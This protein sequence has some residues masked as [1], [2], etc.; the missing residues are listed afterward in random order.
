MIRGSGDR[1]TGRPGR[2]R[3]RRSAPGPAVGGSG[4]GSA[5]ASATV[6]GHG[7]AEACRRG[8]ASTWVPRCG[9]TR[10][11]GVGGRRPRPPAGRRG[12][13]CIEV[14]AGVGW[15]PPAG[16]CRRTARPTRE[17]RPA[18][19]S[20]GGRR[21]RAVV[22]GRVGGGSTSTAGQEYPF[23]SLTALHHGTSRQGSSIKLVFHVKQFAGA[24][25]DPEP[26]WDRDPRRQGTPARLACMGVGRHEHVRAGADGPGGA[27]RMAPTAGPPRPPSPTLG[28]RPVRAPAH[29]A[30]PSTLRWAPECRPSALQRDVPRFGECMATCQ[31]TL[32]GRRAQTIGPGP[33]RATCRSPTTPVRDCARTRGRLHAVSRWR[34]GGVW[35]GCRSGGGSG[36]GTASP[37][38][39]PGTTL[40]P[41]SNVASGSSPRGA[42]PPPATGRDGRRAVRSPPSARRRPGTRRRTPPSPPAGR[43]PGPRPGRTRPRRSA[44]RGPTPRPGPRRHRHPSSMP[45][46]CTASHQELDPPVARVDQRPVALGPGQRPAASPGSPAPLPRSRQAA[47]TGTALRGRA[48]PQGVVEVGEERH[49]VRPGPAGGRPRAPAA[50]G[51]RASARRIHRRGPV[52][53]R[54]PPPRRG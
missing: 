10:R 16:G 25:G 33:G 11:L 51:T 42:S 28:A 3:R 45:E 23:S 2:R 47:P 13:D 54:R 19:G 38:E 43:I 1:A 22:R 15:G 9:P 24:V 41:A 14:G 21:R 6:G 36:R 29:R 31:A 52:C 37:G 8:W 7:L 35:R 53:R 50:A 18:R 20:T 46:A 48:E 27:D 17:C 49:P 32:Q 12:A 30:N 34:T 39:G 40:P 5:A 26:Q 44:R 4:S